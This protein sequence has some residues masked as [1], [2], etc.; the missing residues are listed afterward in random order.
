MNDP[1]PKVKER[2]MFLDALARV[3]NG[4]G[5]YCSFGAFETGVPS[6]AGLLKNMGVSGSG[7]HASP[8]PRYSCRRIRRRGLG[9]KPSRSILGAG[10]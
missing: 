9:A 7:S 6:L 5:G 1:D 2:A 3:L 4:T 8:P 10:R